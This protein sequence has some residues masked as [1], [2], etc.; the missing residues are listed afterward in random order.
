MNFNTLEGNV[1]IVTLENK[2]GRSTNYVVST[3]IV[4]AFLDGN[5]D[6]RLGD[7]YVIRNMKWAGMK[8]QPCTIVSSEKVLSRIEDA[9]I[10]GDY[11]PPI[12]EEF[13]RKYHAP[14]SNKLQM[15]YNISDDFDPRVMED[16]D[17]IET[18]FRQ[19]F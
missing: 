4:D 17:Y 19:I 16:S 13:N 3:E 5:R 12:G 10:V 18:G 7:A 9:L 8:T 15:A 14:L 11:I 1:A 2:N 6:L